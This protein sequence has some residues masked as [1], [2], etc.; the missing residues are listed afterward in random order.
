M[1]FLRTVLALALLAALA[2]PALAADDLTINVIL[3]LTGPGRIRG[4]RG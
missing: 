4:G 2:P 1:K 3:S